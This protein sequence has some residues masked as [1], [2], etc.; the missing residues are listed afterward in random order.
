MK[1]KTPIWMKWF[2]IACGM[3]N[4][5]WGFLFLLFP[6]A[7]LQWIGLSLYPYPWLWRCVGVGI[8]V[9]GLLFLIAAQAPLRHFRLVLLGL[10]AKVSGPVGFAALAFFQLLPWSLCLTSVINDMIWWVPLAIIALRAHRCK[11]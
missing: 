8:L 2:L 1:P 11:A 7:P 9:I 10:L 4:V 6:L 3:Y 5:C